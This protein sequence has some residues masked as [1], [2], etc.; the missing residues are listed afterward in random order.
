ML[1]QR[2]RVQQALSPAVHREGAAFRLE[3]HSLPFRVRHGHVLL[4]LDAA[5]GG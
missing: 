3:Q 2:A 4:R 5:G 1:C